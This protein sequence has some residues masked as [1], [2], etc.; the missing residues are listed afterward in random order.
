MRRKNSRLLSFVLVV[1][2]IVTGV[3][4]F[5][6][7][8][9]STSK[10]RLDDGSLAFVENFGQFDARARYQVLGGSATLWLTED[11]LWI[12]QMRSEKLVALKLSFPGANRNARLEPFGRQKTVYNAFYGRN[13]DQWYAGVPVWSGVRV[14]DLYPGVD[15][16]ISGKNGQLTWGLVCP[17][18][19]ACG[20]QQVTLRVEGATARVG[21]DGLRL[22]TEVGDFTWPLLTLSGS[23]SPSPPIVTRKAEDVYEIAQ[24]FSTVPSAS[25]AQ[26]PS[27]L[28]ETPSGLLAS[29]FI[30]GDDLDGAE[31]VT[32]DAEGAV[33]VTG[34]SGST[35]IYW[36]QSPGT[37]EVE[38]VI[39]NGAH[40]GPIY[41]VKLSA[42]L[43]SRHYMTFIGNEYQSYSAG[44][45]EYGRDIAVDDA[46][47][48]YLTGQTMSLDE[49][50]VTA[51][52]FDRTLNAGADENCT[53]GQTNR[54]CPDA[55][56]VKLNAAG[57]LAYASYLGGSYM[58]LPGETA[59]IGG[60]DYAVA[61]G[62]DAQHHV[63][64]FGTT[65][66][67][68]FPTT[69]GAFDREFSYVDIG[70]NP[71]VFVVKMD[72]AGNGSQ[73]LLYGTYLGSGFINSAGDMIV[74]DDGVVYATGGVEGRATIINGP[75]IDFPTT[76]GAY[77]RTSQCLAYNCK[78][79]FFFKLNP[80]GQGAAD[81]LYGTFFGGT[82][83]D[84]RYWEIEEVTGLAYD[85]SGVVY[86][87]GQ[88]ET[89]D[90][91]VT[92][93][94]YQET[95]PG[96]A[97]A[98]VVSKLDPAGNGAADLVYSSYL[99]G[100]SSDSSEAVAVD[101]DGHIYVVGQTNSDNFPV[102]EMAYDDVRNNDDAY[103]AR[104][105]PMGAGTDDLI[106]SSYFGGTSTDYGLDLTLV[107]SDVVYLTGRTNSGS[108]FP[109][110]AG[111]F[112]TSFGGLYDGYV[113]KLTTAPPYPDL[114]TSTKTVTPGEAA[115][116]ELV[117]Y[118]L[119]LINSGTLSATV[120]V[121]DTL[122]VTLIPQG[123]PVS[124][125]GPAPILAGQ[126]LTWTGTVTT[127]AT[128][129][130]TY[131][132]ELTATKTLTPVI[133]NQAVIDDGLGNVF[134]SRV[135]VNGYRLFLPLVLRESP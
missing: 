7:S 56:L 119:R 39:P 13:P 12:T 21:S 71:D 2:L 83:P 54:P 45:T 57:G 64:I 43:S 51:G 18:Q 55:F 4:I 16:K 127:D 9:A 82:A 23:T 121:T 134:V 130:L 60:N 78:D 106:Y 111:A 22:S 102:T 113:S 1:L 65:N 42:D 26:S 36:P 100:V 20:L 69:D 120:A 99:G 84:T 88:T 114:S 62:V 128:V 104:L 8:A 94:A 85:S 126:T 50:P 77:V 52:A 79:L 108:D 117:T 5:D 105:N 34:F 67:Q 98:V 131:T 49:F 118:T 17:S 101:G 25:S 15:L 80:L 112:D 74:D 11:A 109:I 48:V 35:D 93:G 31:A 10:P 122:P 132:V 70:L 3:L 24:P 91:P 110:T 123:T 38:R 19:R 29:T 89:D 133:V 47:N 116:G 27:S 76:P 135:F 40:T 87:V 81:L 59:N 58:T 41:V 46:G 125:G 53:T 75:K 30:G 90:Y 14:V 96:G 124:S 33:Y 103:V 68:D 73:D 66:S 95:Y 129:T 63:Y 44:I 72:P 86:I 6:V 37:H 97:T 32:R 61:V 107:E 28:Q 92:T 115:V